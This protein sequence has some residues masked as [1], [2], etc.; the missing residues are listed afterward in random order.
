VCPL[1]E[2][3]L[4]REIQN[5]QKNLDF[6]L[7]LCVLGGIWFVLAGDERDSERERE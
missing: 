3:Q 1:G 4:K 7:D 5:A 6:L 2:I